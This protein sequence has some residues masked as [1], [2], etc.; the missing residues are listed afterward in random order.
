M[1]LS[2][3]PKQRLILRDNESNLGR[4]EERCRSG[5]TSSFE[6]LLTNE[7]LTNSSWMRTPMVMVT[8]AMSIVE[9][10]KSAAGVKDSVVGTK[11]LAHKGARSHGRQQLP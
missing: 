4:E 8:R 2:D 5:L 10:I 9:G 3:I 6:V 7:P 1:T 11:D